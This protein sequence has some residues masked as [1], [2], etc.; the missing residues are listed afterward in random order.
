M[1]VL[2]ARGIVKHFGGVTALS[3]ATLTCEEGRIT[4]LIGANGSGKSTICKILVG[5]HQ[6]DAGTITYNGNPVRF[7]MP[8]EARRNGVV[9]A[10]QNLSLSANLTV[11]ENISLG[12]ERTRGLFADD[13]AARERAREWIE[14]LSPGLDIE[15]EVGTLRPGD[16]QIVEITKAMST[17]ARVLF[18]DEPTAALEHE[19]VGNLFKVMREL[20]AQGTAIV[21]ISHRLREITD[22]CDEIII[23]RNGKNV[24]YMDL[25]TETD[26]HAKIVPLITGGKDLKRVEKTR[27]RS[28]EVAQDAPVLKVE[29][30]CVENQLKNICFELKKGEVLGIGGLAGQ[31]QD[32]LMLALA[33]YLRST[34]TVE[35]EGRPVR[36]ASVRDAIRNGVVLVPGDKHS[37]G[38]FVKHT[39][40]DNLV[41]TNFVQNRAPS[42][43]PMARYTRECNDIVEKLSIE[44][45]GVYAVVDHLSGGNQQ[46][47]VLGK[48]L[49]HNPK[50]ILLAD[51]AKG[52]DISTR[53]EIYSLIQQMAD[54]NDM[55]VVLFASDHEELVSNCDRVLVLFEG[56]IVDTIVG[57]ELTEDRIMKASLYIMQNEGISTQ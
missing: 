55:S 53:Q 43:L 3:D 38:L 49:S 12:H 16:M 25:K 44:T 41:Y 39:I 5:V 54:E 36:F 40:F 47:V 15:A 21:F 42:W 46:K 24:G 35:V 19:Q 56:A 34:G 26:V 10:F 27:N 31:G 57:D 52:V 32:E 33:G 7:K 9:M 23:F 17:D 1:S 30:L 14:K 22:I 45:P 18:L 13:M 48:W 4:G 20:A 8:G 2:D 37:Q 50:V 11:W 51:P 6:Y 28:V 29:N